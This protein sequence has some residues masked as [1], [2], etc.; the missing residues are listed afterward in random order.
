MNMTEFDGRFNVRRET[1]WELNIYSYY[2]KLLSFEYPTLE[3]ALNKA[4]GSIREPLVKNDDLGFWPP[5]KGCWGEILE[6]EIT[7]INK[8]VTVIGEKT[9][10]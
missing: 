1:V 10:E 8:V 3:A 4:R 6:K 7:I 5:S 2:S 9:K